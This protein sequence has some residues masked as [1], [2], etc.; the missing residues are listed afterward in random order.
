MYSRPQGYFNTISRFAHFT[1]PF[2]GMAAAFTATTCVATN[3]R[4]KNDKLN[5][6]MGG[7]ASGAIY[8]AWRGSAVS[9]FLACLA[10]GTAGVVKKMSL[11]EGWTFMPQSSVHAAGSLRGVQSDWTIIKDPAAKN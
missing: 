4:H 10:L 6:F 2:V 11:D 5:Y 8:G 1:V 9:G 3:F 7:V